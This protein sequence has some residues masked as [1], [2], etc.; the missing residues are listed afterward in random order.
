MDNGPDWVSAWETGAQDR[1]QALALSR[2]GQK[3]ARLAECDVIHIFDV[4][5]REVHS[6]ISMDSRPWSISFSWDSKH[7][8]INTQAGKVD[9]FNI[10]TGNFDQ[11]YEGPPPST[12]IIRAVF[13]GFRDKFVL[14]AA[15]GR[16]LTSWKLWAD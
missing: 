3:L 4:G 1:T 10:D 16:T 8:L 11:F 7:I 15:E 13:G 12:F 5:T 14:S 9:L 6:S 2:N